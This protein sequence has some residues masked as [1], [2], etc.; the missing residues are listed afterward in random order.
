M[1]QIAIFFARKEK[2]D[3]KMSL[4]IKNAE[5]LF[6]KFERGLEELAERFL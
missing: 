5:T 2:K 3:E 1:I 4:L 6:E